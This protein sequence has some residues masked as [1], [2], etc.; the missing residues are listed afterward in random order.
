MKRAAPDE[1]SPSKRTKLYQDIFD[2]SDLERTPQDILDN[3]LQDDTG[4]ISCKVYMT[5]RP[6]T[7][8]KAII[9]TT[10]QAAPP[11]RFDLE[12]AGAC[13]EFF[14]EIELKAQDEFLLAL[15]LAQMEK[16][17]KASRLCNI[18]LKLVY[19]EGVIIKFV[20]RQGPCEIVDTWQC[21]SLHLVLDIP[22]NMGT[23]S[24]KEEA[25]KFEDSWFHSAQVPLASIEDGEASTPSSPTGHRDATPQNPP[26]GPSPLRVPDVRKAD[27]ATAGPIQQ[28]VLA[29]EPKLSKKQ[30]KDQRK[31]ERALRLASDT[32]KQ[33]ADAASEG[34]HPERMTLST[35]N[36]KLDGSPTTPTLPHHDSPKRRNAEITTPPSDQTTPVVLPQ[37]PAAG[38]VTASGRYHALADLGELT[39][40]TLFNVIAVV[41]DISPISTTRTGEL[42]CTMRLAD[43]SNITLDTLN[44]SG[45]FKVNCFT[46]KH[47]KWLPQPTLGDILV[48]RDLKIQHRDLGDT[49]EAESLGIGGGYAFSP[50]FQPEEAEIRY[51]IKTADWW[52]D[53]EKRRTSTGQIHQVASG[54]P[55]RQHRLIS[56]AGPH[57]QPSGFFDCTVE[58]LHGHMNDNNVY[59]LYVTDYTINPS[60]APTQAP[61]CPPGLAD[62]VLK[63]EAWDQASDIVKDIFAREYLSIKNARMMLSRGGYVEGKLAETKIRR[64]DV[65]ADGNVDHHFKE[66][67]ERK[68]L[69]QDANPGVD[70]LDEFDH[71]TIGEATAGKHF[72]CVVEV[73]HAVH[74][75]DGTSCIDVTDYTFRDELVSRKVEGTWGIGLDGRILRVILF[76]QQVEMAN[77]VQVGS[78]YSIKKLRMK[79]S[80]AARQFQGHLGGVERLITPLDANSEDARLLKQRKEEWQKGSGVSRVPAIADAPVKVEPVQIVVSKRPKNVKSIAQLQA[81]EKCPNKSRIFAKVVDF[82]PWNLADVTIFYCA[83]CKRD[84]Y[85]YVRHMFQMYFLVQ[86]EDGG[87]LRVSVHDGSSIF[88][89]LQRGDIGTDPKVHSALTGRLAGMLGNLLEVH[90]G[91]PKDE[92]TLPNTPMLSL[93]I[94]SWE[95]DDGKHA[96]SLAGCDELAA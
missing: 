83:Q 70:Q 75:G 63:I 91:F 49:P 78:F 89:G 58:V 68:K 28:P 53:M 93:I 29:Q 40:Y 60:V 74:D 86:D 71:K 66:L 46:K 50:F 30:K 57:V 17:S 32:K 20:K 11:L 10:S 51:C 31:K 64:L 77:V 14:P 35:T 88:S 2:D 87:Q 25:R 36:Q 94:D 1:E 48:M 79:Q 6:T 23:R 76:Q 5:W 24:V 18:P 37:I 52:A 22:A 39:V 82:H 62:H 55:R 73:L 80:A 16:T 44:S 72:H 67:L 26:P 92:V 12:F 90:S 15:K 41:V 38:L 65:E 4:Y 81:D 54:P 13:K 7:K 9:Q 19:E 85:E 43:P 59:S 8:H 47:E 33:S 42:S 56:D 84:D 3:G 34:P 95:V 27:E 61:W 45:G 96:Y 21:T 69:W